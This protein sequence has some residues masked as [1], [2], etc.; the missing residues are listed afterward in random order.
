ML[1]LVATAHVA[2]AEIKV[3]ESG[4]VTTDPAGAP[5]I[6]TFASDEKVTVR[7]VTS[8]SQGYISTNTE[9]NAT[10]YADA[11]SLLCTTP[12][13]LEMPA[14]PMRIRFGDYNP[15]NANKAIDFNF[16]AGDNAYRIKPFN[17]GK[18]VTGF[19][20]AVI[21]GSALIT[22]GALG[23]V[24]EDNRVPMLVLAGVGGGVLIGGAVMIGGSRASAESIPVQPPIR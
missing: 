18:F 13:K 10:G 20:L 23:I 15:M 6:V 9:V 22:C 3:F 11:S 14:G 19:L 1:W 17:G 7:Q 5:A 2:A 8:E 4:G 24:L 12:C 16:R 21:G